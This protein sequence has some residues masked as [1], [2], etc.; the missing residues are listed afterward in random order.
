MSLK[1]EFLNS[2]KEKHTR[3]KFPISSV[4]ECW[5]RKYLELK[6]LCQEEFSEEKLR[7]FDI[8][9]DIHK[10]ITKELLEKEGKTM[11]LVASEVNVPSTKYISGR[12][13]NIVSINGVNVIVDVKSA[14]DWTM[15]S[16]RN[17]EDVEENY[18]NQVLLYMHLSGIHK[19]ILLFVSKTKGELEEVEVVYDKEKAEKLVQ[20]IENFFH[21]YVNKNIEPAKCDGG[22][23]GCDCC[24]T[25][26]NWGVS[27][28][29]I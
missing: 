27:K 10:L 22:R 12:L 14:S 5:R 7:L 19:G 16:I 24:G 6:G 17:G 20:E 2:K 29:S 11:H 21:T 26:G 25:K 4:G 28:L 8:G 13:D 15:K 18:K 9:S 1:K 3:R 23:F